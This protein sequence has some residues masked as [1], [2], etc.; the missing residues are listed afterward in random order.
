MSYIDWHG[1]PGYRG[2]IL[3]HFDSSMQ[4][5]DI[6]CGT[7]W[8]ADHFARYVGVDLHAD[9]VVE[10]RRRGR[11]VVLADVEHPL[12]FR[13]GCFDAALLKDLLEHTLDPVAVVREARRVLRADGLLY[14][15]SPDAQRWVWDDYTHRRPMPKVALRRILADNGF[16]L[17]TLGYESV[18]PGS[19]IISGWTSRKRRPL[20]LRALARIRI[21]RRNTVATAR[22][23]P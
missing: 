10:G 13:D 9:A 11:G 21:F 7:A 14:V 19:S 6:G 1:A 4:V 22:R 20:P 2:D 8:V 17:V 23:L 5:L 15:S 3:R 18:T 16:R 12:P